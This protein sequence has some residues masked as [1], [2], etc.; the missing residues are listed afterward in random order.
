MPYY[1]GS[2]QSSTKDYVSA[3]TTY[4]TVVRYFPTQTTQDGYTYTA[5]YMYFE[6]HE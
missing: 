6:I 2:W 5:K 4:Y 1:I 3:N